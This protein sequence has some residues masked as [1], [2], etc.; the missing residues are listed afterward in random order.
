MKRKLIL[1]AI[2]LTLVTLGFLVLLAGCSGE[3]IQAVQDLIPLQEQLAAEYGG[4]NIKVE[5]E[6]GN[7]LGVTFVNSSS[8]GLARDRKAEQ[9]REIASFVC[10]NYAS[11][12]KIAQVWVAFEIHQDG[13]IADT[14]SS[15]T[16]VFEKGELECSD[17]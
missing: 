10:E 2:A 11:M 15:A 7:T 14:T 16:F 4:S 3:G 8:N 17:S 5:I 1:S 9:A 13:S 12:G 6:D